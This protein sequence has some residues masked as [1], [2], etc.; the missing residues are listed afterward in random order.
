MRLAISDRALAQHVSND[1]HSIEAEQVSRQPD[2]ASDRVTV[3]GAPRGA[4]VS[5]LYVT[6]NADAVPSY[7]ACT[8]PAARIFLPVTDIDSSHSHPPSPRP[9]YTSPTCLCATLQPNVSTTRATD[10]ADDGIPRSDFLA[11]ADNVNI[12]TDDWTLTGSLFN[13]A[14]EACDASASLSQFSA[15]LTL[16]TCIFTHVLRRLNVPSTRCR[17]EACVHAFMHASWRTSCQP[18]LTMRNIVGYDD[19]G[20]LVFGGQNFQDGAQ[21]ITWRQEDGGVIL[22]AD[23]PNGNG[24]MVHSSI[25]LNDHVGNDNGQFVWA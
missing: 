21:N 2:G 25:N 3:V 16:C 11:T 19:S 15:C 18:R 1:R 20:N 5:F 4:T 14:G 23:C 22:E 6:R 17:Y 7:K 10:M 13:M 12:N 9:D 8:T 24:D